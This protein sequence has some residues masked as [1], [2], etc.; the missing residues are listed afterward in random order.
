M[1]PP[2][3][4]VII[5]FGKAYLGHNQLVQYLMKNKSK[6]RMS[7]ITYTENEYV[8]L[9][10]CLTTRGEKGMNMMTSCYI[11]NGTVIVIIYHIHFPS[12]S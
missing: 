9:F 3:N 12:D 5:F 4:L 7:D 10:I 8:N 6:R 2:Q 1:R 11:F